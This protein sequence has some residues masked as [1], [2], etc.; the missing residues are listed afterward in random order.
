MKFRDLRRKDVLAPAA[1]IAASLVVQGM[2]L[3]SGFLDDDFL[4]FYESQKR[5]FLAVVTRPFGN[6]FMAFFKFVVALLHALFGLHAGWYFAIVLLTHLANVALLY[7]IVRALSRS[8]SVAG[9]AAA[10]WGSAPAFQGTLQWFSAYSHM[11]STT[12]VL[13]PLW[14]MARAAEARRPPTAWAL[15]RTSLALFAGSATM[16]TGSVTAAIF[17][18]VALILLPRESAPLRTALWLLP[19]ALASTL[20]VAWFAG[21]NVTMR[22]LL[23]PAPTIFVFLALIAYAVGMVIAGPLVTIHAD[24]KGIGLF[25]WGS[26]DAAVAVSAVFFLALFGVVA[27]RLVRGEWTERRVLLAVLVLAGTLYAS[28]AVGRSWLAFGNSLTWIATRDRYHYDA[29]PGLI[30]AIAVAVA[31]LRPPLAWSPK[32]PVAI[33]LVALAGA[34]VAASC[35]VARTTYV[36]GQWVRQRWARDV[37]DRTDGAIRELAAHIPKGGVLYLRN[38]PFAAASLVYALGAPQ[39]DFPGIGA[40]WIIAHGVDPVDGRTIRFVEENAQLLETIRAQSR[41]EVASMFVAPKDVARVNAPMRTIDASPLP[42]LNPWG[43]PRFYR[44]PRQGQAAA[45]M[46]CRESCRPN[47]MVRYSQEHGCECTAAPGAMASEPAKPPAPT[48]TAVP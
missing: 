38:D 21:G 26:C 47:T 8:E 5:G 1:A 4:Y 11:L 6:H 2:V 13:W 25:P 15:I 34:Y 24:G 48:R 14:E 42:S 31:R 23:S 7:S 29:N 46:A 39:A 10:L 22:G 9:L 36:G 20:T 30:I 32:R 37:M 16:L 12:A 19:S 44:L 45:Q 35:L 3:G 27:W 41:P 17:P 18:A 28:I 43:R 40:Y 33:L